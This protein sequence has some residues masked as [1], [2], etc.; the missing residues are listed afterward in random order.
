[1]TQPNES[2]STDACV[3]AAVLPVQIATPRSAAAFLTDALIKR[4]A[5]INHRKLTTEELAAV[6][7][8][9]P[10]TIRAALCR[11]GHYLGLKPIKLPNRKLLWD[12]A[13]AELLLSGEGL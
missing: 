12:A 6:L 8:V 7:R 2:P 4:R 5:V 13:E 11:Q 10:Q 1:M 3:T 9:A